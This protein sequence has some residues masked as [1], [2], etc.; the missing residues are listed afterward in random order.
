MKLVG[1]RIYLRT[2]TVKDLEDMARWNRDRELQEYVD[3]NLPLE[4]HQL[5]RWYH[6]NV[7][8]RHY[9]IFAIVTHAGRLIGDLELDHICWNK[10]EAELRIRIGEKDCW[11]QG[12]GTE[13]IQLIFEYLLVTKKFNRIYLRV[14]S[15]NR[16]AIRCYLKNGFR[17]IGILRRR[18][19]GWK[20]IILMEIDRTLFQKGIQSKNV[21]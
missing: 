12:L 21:G 17:R 1:K 9:Q 15:F 2:L 18:V 4:V 6:Q 7:P 19:E 10:R 13:A 20:D 3:C 14:Y 16:R 8:D 11:D 5:K